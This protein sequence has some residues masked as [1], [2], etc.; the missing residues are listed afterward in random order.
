MIFKGMIHGDLSIRVKLSLLAYFAFEQESMGR[1]RSAACPI[2][3]RPSTRGRQKPCACTVPCKCDRC[4][5]QKIARG[6]IK[7]NEGWRW[8]WRCSGCGQNAC[9]G[10]E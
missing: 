5:C 7:C 6:W 10:G 8:L 3:Q 2:C 1:A 4:S 9:K